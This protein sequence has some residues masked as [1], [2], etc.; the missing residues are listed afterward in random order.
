MPKAILFV[1]DEEH[2]LKALR[3]LF[4]QTEYE[5]F[6]ATSGRG[7]LEIVAAEKIDLIISD[8]RMPEMDGYQLLKQVKT[9][10]PAIMRVILS[11]YSDE[12]E[13]IKAIQ[14]G[15][16]RMYLMKPW[17]NEEFLTVIDR[18]LALKDL[19]ASKNLLAVMNSLNRLPTLPTIY[20]RICSLIEE[21]A[22]AESIAA[23]IEEDP[24]ITVRILQITNSVLYGKKTG[25]VKEAI[26]FLG[27]AN[28][29]N[30][31][32]SVS[33][34]NSVHIEHNSHFTQD[35]LW[36]HVTLSNHIVQLIYKK[37]LHKKLPSISSAAGLLHDIGRLILLQYFPQQYQEI[38]DQANTNSTI[39]ICDLENNC[40]NISHEEMGGF[41]LNWWGMP[42]PIIEAAL[43][44]HAPSD[45][46][47]INREL[48]SVVHLA[49]YYSWQC[50]G[51]GLLLHLDIN[52]FQVLNITKESCEELIK[53]IPLNN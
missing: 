38:T 47:V 31:V 10:Y 9:Q 42:Q 37:L 11:G 49:D 46:R 14:D 6:F 15:S 2:I 32:L 28:I 26:V 53:E 34:L 4:A 33:I 45:V 18:L 48:V 16:S 51:K 7:A 12:Q 35:L 25:S 52:V 1:D 43:F 36:R 23:V 20:A 8:M 19:F 24:V 3:R 21:N 50:L 5:V 41:L 40:L 39:S 44:H 27:L 22:G 29:K 17:D 30:I 13:I